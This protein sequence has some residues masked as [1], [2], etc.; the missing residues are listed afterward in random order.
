MGDTVESILNDFIERRSGII[1]ALSIDVDKFQ[2]QC[3]SYKYSSGLDKAIGLY[4]HP[5]GTWQLQKASLTCPPRLP[6]PALGIN[7]GTEDME[8]R[9]WLHLVA[10]HC[11]AWLLSVAFFHATS[12][13]FDRSE[14]K[15]LLDKINTF[16]TIVEVVGKG[17][18]DN[19]QDGNEQD[20]AEQDDEEEE[21]EQDDEEEDEQDEAEEDILCETYGRFKLLKYEFWI[22]CDTCTRWYHGACE[23][24]TR[25]D[26]EN[27][28]YYECIACSK[29][30]K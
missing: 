23:L 9:D 13:R 28:V 19:E 3:N 24:V 11:D 2:Q 12:N 22:C 8:H 1:Q 10:A 27:F 17:Q 6:A 14:R 21:D 16:A 29:R 25:S 15:S 4:G 5:N 30:F 7:L 18:N 26:A 20:E